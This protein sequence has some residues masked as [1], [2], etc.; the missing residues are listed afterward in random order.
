M[1]D[2]QFE[3]LTS[4]DMVRIEQESILGQIPSLRTADAL[5]F[6]KIMD[7]QIADILKQK[8]IPDLPAEWPGGGEAPTSPPVAIIRAPRKGE[9]EVSNLERSIREGA[10]EHEPEQ[11]QTPEFWG[12]KQ[13]EGAAEGP[14]GDGCGEDGEPPEEQE[15]LREAVKNVFED[16]SPQR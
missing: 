10:A 6:R 2:R 16:D 8:L 15:K 4:D 7:A 14:C 11:I 13:R 5:A 12:R 3:T 1:A 9:A